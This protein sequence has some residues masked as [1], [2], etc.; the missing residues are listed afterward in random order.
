MAY[1]LLSRSKFPTFGQG[2][3]VGCSWFRAARR[4]WSWPWRSRGSTPAGFKCLTFDDSYHGRS[5][6]AL[7]LTGSPAERSPRLGPLLPGS[8]RVPSFRPALCPASAGDELAAEESLSAIR[9]A[10]REQGDIA[11]VVAEPM[12]IDARRPPDWYWPGVRAL[13]DRHGALLIFDEVP[14]GLGKMGEF[15]SAASCSAPRPT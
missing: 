11:C 3:T 4:P 1:L 12:A 7:S 13:C 6:G 10:M 14:T 5:F 2:W 15:C 8:I 9:E